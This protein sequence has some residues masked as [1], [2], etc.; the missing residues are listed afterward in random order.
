LSRVVTSCSRDAVGLPV[1][2]SVGRS[3]PRNFLSWSRVTAGSLLRSASRGAVTTPTTLPPAIRGAPARRGWVLRAMVQPLS[4][5]AVAEPVMD[6]AEGLKR[7]TV[8]KEA[9]VMGPPLNESAI[10]RG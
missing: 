6:W 2:A 7:S 4:L 1:P 8:G 10:A 5:G 9:Q 3:E